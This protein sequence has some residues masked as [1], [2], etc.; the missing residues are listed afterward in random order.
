MSAIAGVLTEWAKPRKRSWE[1]DERRIN[2]MWCQRGAHGRSKT[3]RAQ[4]LTRLFRLL[5]Q[6]TNPKASNHALPKRE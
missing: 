6:E 2:A 3:L 1:E 5:Q 4:T